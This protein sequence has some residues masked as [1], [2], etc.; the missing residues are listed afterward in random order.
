MIPI[1]YAD[2][3]SSWTTGGLG[4]LSDAISCTV[5]EA[6]NGSYELE[7]RYPTNGRLFDQI[8]TRRQI[9]AAPN[10]HAQTQ[11]F[12]IY[13]IS[14][15]LRGA[16]TINARHIS[17]D[18]SGYVVTPF[19]GNNKATTAAGALA[20]IATTTPTLT[21]YVFWTDMSVTADMECD[22]PTSVRS[23]LGPAETE[24]TVLAIYGGDLEYDRMSVK[25]HANRGQDRGFAIEY[26]VNMTD[27][28]HEEDAS[29]QWSGVIPYWK[30]KDELVMGDICTPSPAL[31]FSYVKPVDLTNEFADKPS[32]ADLNSHGAAY[33]QRHGIGAPETTITLSFVP[34]NARGLHAIEELHL[35]DEVTVRYT[36]LG[37][38]VKKSVVQTKYNVLT[39]RYDS[40]EVGQRKRFIAE[41]IAAPIG[42]K[43]SGGGGGGGGGKKNS[44]IAEKAVTV[45]TISNGAVTSTKIADGAVIENK[46]LDKAV[47]IAKM[48]DGFEVLWT[49]VL[50]AESIVAGTID[51]DHVGTFSTVQATDGQFGSISTGN[52]GVQV[53]YITSLNLGGMPV[54]IDGDGYLHV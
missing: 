35:F 46:I 7:M 26:G 50:A 24:G 41:T 25:L 36:K 13:R 9:L 47:S 40:V 54:S 16:V 48:W 23:L 34:P 28:T 44:G 27:L 2:N 14:K 15:E 17:Y 43:K 31:S 53:A 29:D 52:I 32:K 18:L 3:E 10:P 12:R 45:N 19:T 11:P 49:K 5:T 20:K 30:S 22:E 37:I 4:P 42:S 38:D 1:L 39:D 33:V 51:V 21:G 6:A 8:Q